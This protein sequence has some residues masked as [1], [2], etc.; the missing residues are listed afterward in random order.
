[1]QKKERAIAGLTSYLRSK[2]H[3]GD[4][5][6]H[7]LSRQDTGWPELVKLDPTVGEG[8][9]CPDVIEQIVLEA[10]YAGHIQK[11]AEQIERFQSMESRRIPQH[12]DFAAVPQLRIEAK[13]KLARVRPI[14]LGQASRISGITPADLAVLLFY[15]G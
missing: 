4:T 8:N 14:N 1:L 5:L 13:E 6:M 10:K 11:Q 7:W 3:E 9:E 2:R 12:F 15:L